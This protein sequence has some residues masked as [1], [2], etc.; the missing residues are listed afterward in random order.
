MPDFFDRY[1]NRPVKSRELSLFKELKG[2][3]SVARSRAPSLRRQLNGIDI[4]EIKKRSDL[5]RIPVLRR[6]D[7]RDLQVEQP[8][9]G[10]L[11]GSR[12]S[13]LK[14]LHVS[15]GPWF[16]PEGQSRDYWGGRAPC[17]PQARARAMSFSIACLIICVPRGI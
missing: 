1:E 16:Q 15:P 10:G 11:S 8:P 2:I 13:S 6:A 3:I 7:L 5:A 14:R 9:F 4:R 17:S 12:L